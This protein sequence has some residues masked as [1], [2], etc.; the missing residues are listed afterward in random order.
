MNAPPLQSARTRPAS[1]TDPRSQWIVAVTLALGTALLAVTLRV[2]RGSG[3]LVVLSLMVAAVWVGGA[4]L[5][6]PLPWRSVPQSSRLR[7]VLGSSLL[8]C[9][10]GLAFFGA[11]LVAR[12]LP[13]LSTALSS[14]VGKAEAGSGL[15][16]VAALLNG[17]AEE[18]FFRGALFGAVGPRRPEVV[19]TIIYVLV[20]AATGNVALMVAAAVM[21]AIFSRQRAITGSI[22]A[23]LIT[24]VTWSTLL[25]VLLPRY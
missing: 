6:G 7:T 25:L 19:T 5:A 24:H 2:P 13:L 10:A 8:G 22:V 4:R 12:R 17:V 11:Y 3:W 9:V 16:V 18:V 14:I 15:V 20:T 1:S 23:P 21:G